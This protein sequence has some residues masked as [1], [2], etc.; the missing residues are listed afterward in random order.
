M[1]QG[2]QIDNDLVNSIVA[3]FGNDI[4]G[5]LN[6]LELIGARSGQKLNR[7]MVLSLLKSSSTL[8]TQNKSYLETMKSIFN[9]HINSTM[10]KSGETN[11]KKVFHTIL[12][13]I[14]PQMLLDGIFCNF[15]LCDSVN[16]HIEKNTCDL[17]DSLVTGLHRLNMVKRYQLFQIERYLSVDLCS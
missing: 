7:E 14:E 16:A 17:L 4:S 6:F 5:C 11:S 3:G 1:T 8:D 12:D 2:V 15:S 10:F 13:S 9:K